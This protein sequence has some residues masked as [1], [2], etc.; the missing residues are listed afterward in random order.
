MLSHA[1][2][3]GSRNMCMRAEFACAANAASSSRAR[4]TNGCALFT[5]RHSD[6]WRGDSALSCGIVLPEHEGA[7]YSQEASN[8]ARCRIITVQTPLTRF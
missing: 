1:A 3:N 8:T 5:D 4:T 7:H 2:A 6:G